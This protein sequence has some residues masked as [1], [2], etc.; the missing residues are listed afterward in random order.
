[1]ISTTA[2]N[3]PSPHVKSRGRKCRVKTLAF[4]S[5]LVTPPEKGKLKRLV[6]FDVSNQGVV[7]IECVAIETG[8]V[9]EA[10][11]FSK[12]CS[13]VEAASRRLER[14]IKREEVRHAKA[15][16]DLERSKLVSKAV[17]KHPSQRNINYE[18]A[19]I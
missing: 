6:H 9:C 10:N 4:D 5:Y 11:S 1:M 7:K 3:D 19:T 14:N 12:M 2:I 18:S 15:Q 8:E 13:H 17:K 16:S